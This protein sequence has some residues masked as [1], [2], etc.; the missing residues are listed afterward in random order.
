VRS[1]TLWTAAEIAA[2]TGGTASGSFA[3][4]SVTFDSREVIGGE[5]FVA[6][7]GETA[8]GHDFVEAAHARGAAGCLVSRPVQHPHVRVD[9]T[10]AGLLA[11]GTAAR[12]RSAAT[13]VGVTG[14]VG[15]TSVKEALRRAFQQIE[16]DATHWS[17]KSYNNHTGVPLSLARMPKNT[18]YGV[19]E[20][21][22]SHAGELAALTRLVRPH[23]AVV[24]W[25]APAHRAHFA[26]ED[27]IA[28]AKAEIFEGLEPGGTAVLPFDNPHYPRL[29][30]KAE[31][32]A[33]RIL[34]FGRDKRAAVHLVRSAADASGT[35]VI[36][37]V[38]G[39][40]CVYRVS[41]PGDHWVLNSLAVLAAVKAA[42]ADLA[43]AALGLGQIAGMAGRGEQ[44]RIAT[45]GGELLLIDESYNANPASV[46][47]ALAVLGNVDA[48]RKIVVLGAMRELGEDSDAMHAAL[49]DP[50]IASGAALAILVGHETTP[51]ADVLQNRLE[52]R[53]AEGHEAALLLLRE[54]MAAGD[55][56]LVKGSN[57]VGLG[58]LVA[59]LK[60]D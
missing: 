50:V 24:T 20:M 12:S 27:A 34:N 52:V 2:A 28:D 60:K 51:L 25:V 15:K 18:R 37:D 40:T 33:A 4:G 54:V 36:A 43:A 53:R 57:S 56:V 3:A 22:M 14:S 23:I 1:V 29:L 9:D 58:R 32:H 17:V 6:L 30:A 8:D 46:A 59:A 11:L 35:M 5:L 31:Q 49:A 55:A 39:D 44:C 7:R 47:A 21:G 42:G 10:Y 48:T 45:A 13:I 38:C 19:F 26:S 16:P 41:M